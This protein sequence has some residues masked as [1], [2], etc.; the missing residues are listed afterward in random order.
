MQKPEIQKYWLLL[1]PV[2]FLLY[3]A[4]ASL[5][6]VF[7]YPDEKYYTDAV[8]QMMEKGDYFTPYAA[9]GSPRFLKPIL[10]YWVLMGSYAIFGISTFTSRLFFWLAGALLVAI[11]FLM[12]RSLTQN[13]KTAII[14]A[15]I[16]ASNPLVLISAG[17][18]IPDILLTLF[19]TISAWGFLEILVSAQPRKSHYWMAY[20]GAA[21]AFETKGFPAAAF[22]GAS[23]LYL[24][25]NPWKKIN[26]RL[27]F[28][29]FSVIVA[30][31]VALSWFVVMYFVHGAV[32]FESFFADQVGDRIS[33][34]IVQAVGNAS[35]GI[36]NLAAFLIPWIFI[37]LWKPADLK[38]QIKNSDNTKKALI[39]FIFLWVVLI[40]FMAGAV[41]KFY[42][43][44]ILPAI[45]LV[46][47]FFALVSSESKTGIKKGTVSVLFV[48]NVIVLTINI[49]YGIFIDSTL[50]F[51][52]GTLFSLAVIVLYKTGAF[53]FAGHETI[54]ANGVM[55][56]YFSGF[57]LLYP[58][59]MPNPGKQLV[60]SLRT[61]GM[62][63][64]DKVYVYGNIRTASNIRIHSNNKMDVI[65]MSNVFT[66][67]ETPA[68]FLV[69]DKKQQ[70]SLNLS[71][72]N[73]LKG[74]E[75]WSGVPVSKFPYFMQ[76]AVQKLKANGTSYLIAKPK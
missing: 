47:M 34:K 55:L 3:S 13:R 18:S 56:L 71:N 43:R 37:A 16:T 30:V 23:M 1:I 24:V 28:E 27:V 60:D 32:Y 14:A 26:F 21:L 33:G 29:P 74:S 69:F 6:F 63:E 36:F 20:L 31:L 42:D 51:V 25:F 19:L 10:T 72:Y 7:H 45:P 61:Q 50:L 65:S 64:A 67:P 70:D 68:H 38:T 35:L 44:Y 58:L 48:L 62:A 17:R 4:P 40:I 22:A 8:L 54:I 76:P 12:V 59:L 11:T 46:A 41:F 5:D 53:R 57:V 66:L 39:G 2:L 15:F 75:E 73:V 52:I 9:D 49:F